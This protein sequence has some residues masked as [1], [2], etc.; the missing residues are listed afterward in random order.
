MRRYSRNGKIYT[1]LQRINRFE[2]L[3]DRLAKP[4]TRVNRIG[5]RAGQLDLRASGTE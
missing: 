5:S 2:T 4:L 1:N 3:G